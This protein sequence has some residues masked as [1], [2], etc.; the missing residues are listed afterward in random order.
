MN[1]QNIIRFIVGAV[2]VLVPGRHQQLAKVA[3]RLKRMAAD[4][5]TQADVPAEL[6]RL[7]AHP[8]RLDAKPRA[9][10]PGKSTT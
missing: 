4:V 3:E 1:L 9:K 2:A 6:R 8:E 10:E 5:W 7:V